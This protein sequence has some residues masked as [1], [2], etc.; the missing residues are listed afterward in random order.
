MRFVLV[1]KSQRAL[2]L[3]DEY[4]G[5]WGFV[6]SNPDKL[7]LRVTGRELW[8]LAKQHPDKCQI[9]PQLWR[10]AKRVPQWLRDELASVEQAVEPDDTIGELLVKLTGNEDFARD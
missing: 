4:T 8:E 2:E 5:Q 3:L 6:W 9:I 10:P 1:K 7:L